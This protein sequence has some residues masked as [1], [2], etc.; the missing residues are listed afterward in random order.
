M[1]KFL[2]DTI[3]VLIPRKFLFKYEENLRAVYSTFY[4]G[5]KY[6]CNVCQKKLR[7]FI[8]L[9][10]SDFLCPKCGSLQRN[11]RLFYILE[12]E[13]LK[14]NIAVLDFSPSRSL[15]RKLKKITAINYQST[16]LSGDFIAEN[17]FD[18]TNLSIA[19]DSF[20]LII[21]YHILEHVIEDIKAMKELLR[22]LKS[23]GQILIQTPFKEGEIY[24]DRSIVSENE[25]LIHF[26]QKDHVRI[27]SAE[28]LKNRLVSCGFKVEIRTNFIDQN[29]FGFSK[30][31]T[32]LIASKI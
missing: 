30:N 32:I 9:K 16:D 3:S 31:E 6:Q 21:C 27:Y 24:E 2:K 19:D 5:N 18:I 1:Y 10:N 7:K 4:T 28:G 13:F 8:S 12:T 23:E 11:R 15:Y 29:K 17:Q 22:I 26:G 14:P 25:R 20:D